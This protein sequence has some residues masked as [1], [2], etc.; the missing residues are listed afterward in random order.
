MENLTVTKQSREQLLS[1]FSQILVSS[2]FAIKKVD[3]TNDSTEIVIDDGV[4]R[5]D[6]FLIIRTLSTGGWKDKPN[7]K[8][9]Q[10]A[11]IKDLIV[12][13][14]KI[15]TFMLCS[16][17]KYKDKT[18][19]IVW[20]AYLYTHHK[21]NRSCYI[22]I[23]AIEK[24]YEKGYFLSRDFDQEI[25]LSDESHFGLLIRDYISFNY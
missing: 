6:L 4:R 1:A 12:Y 22:N 19:V 10:V 24:C 17:T 9:I 16:M 13:T 15:R 14:N 11:N 7:I 3:T 2:G 18:I 25:W 8:R 23:D 20:N 5:F 21:T